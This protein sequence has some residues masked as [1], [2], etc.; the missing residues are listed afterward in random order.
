MA[1]ESWRREFQVSRKDL[2]VGGGRDVGPEHYDE[3]LGS[4]EF[5]IY[6]PP[7]GKL[8]G[9]K[10]IRSIMEAEGCQVEYPGYSSMT[11]NERY[12][13][14]A[15]TRGGLLIPDTAILRAHRWAHKRNFLHSF[16]RPY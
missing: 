13:V 5:Y 2:R 11:P 9:Y 14:V 15:I 3:V 10:D 1:G 7:N 6:V 16:W 12:S 4:S 8:K